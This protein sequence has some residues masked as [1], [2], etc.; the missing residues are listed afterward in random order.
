[1]KTP[2]CWTFNPIKVPWLKA[3]L[4]QVMFPWP[5]DIWPTLQ[6]SNMVC[7]KIHHYI[8]F[9]NSPRLKASWL[10]IAIHED[11]PNFASRCHWAF[12]RSSSATWPSRPT[13]CCDSMVRFWQVALR[14]GRMKQLETWQIHGKKCQVEVI[15]YPSTFNLSEKTSGSIVILVHFQ[16][17]IRFHS[18]LSVLEGKC[19]VDVR[20]W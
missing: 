7:W 19:L 1:M 17:K 12:I 11:R 16:K 13:F 2:L 3:W 5:L 14:P 8:Q 10:R 9:D 6:S 4:F 15:L 18:Y 20:H